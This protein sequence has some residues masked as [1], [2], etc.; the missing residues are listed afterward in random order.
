[1]RSVHQLVNTD[2]DRFNNICGK[3]IPE[4]VKNDKP[5]RPQNGDY[6][7][8]K[9]D[10]QGYRDE[11]AIHEKRKDDQLGEEEA[12]DRDAEARGL[13]LALND[14]HWKQPKG[15]VWPNDEHG[16]LRKGLLP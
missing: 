10:L 5:R 7:Y 6:C 11:Y 13:K 9:G 15:I 2:N 16:V 3:W 14:K 1:M 8:F 12:L 4:F